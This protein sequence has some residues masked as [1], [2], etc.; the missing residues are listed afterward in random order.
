MLE[1]RNQLQASFNRYHLWRVEKNVISLNNFAELKK[2][3]GWQKNPVLDDSTLYQ[4]EVIEDVNE[5]RIRDA[6]VLGT[7]CCNIEAKNILEIGTATG[8][9]TALMALNAPKSQIHTLNIDRKST[10]LNSS[11]LVIS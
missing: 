1:V 7:V 10:R 5:R 11:H 4:F 8:H 3:F 2:V 9:G 6:E